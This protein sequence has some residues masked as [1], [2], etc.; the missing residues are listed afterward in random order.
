L[1]RRPEVH[2]IRNIENDTALLSC[3]VIQDAPQ[4]RACVEAGAVRELRVHAKVSAELKGT[5]EGVRELT[6]RLT[7]MWNGRLGGF[8]ETRLCTEEGGIVTKLAKCGARWIA[9][10]VV[11]KVAASDQERRSLAERVNAALRDDVDDRGL[12]KLEKTLGMFS[13]PRPEFSLL[14]LLTGSALAETVDVDREAQ[15][16]ETLERLS[17]ALETRDADQVAP[18]FASLTE[19]QKDA[20]TEY[21]QNMD[22]SA[23]LKVEFIG[24]AVRF[25]GENRAEASFLRVDSFHDGPTHR[26]VRLAVRVNAVLVRADG[27]WKVS[28]L[29]RSR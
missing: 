2:F 5:S 14:D 20:L 22:E 6:L 29:K 18:V 26:E 12:E 1:Q 17:R 21:F 9:M 8:D 19:T 24:P 13:L 15:V 28:S 4:R 10:F 16:R 23:A 25:T 11:D 3:T 27:E 7:R